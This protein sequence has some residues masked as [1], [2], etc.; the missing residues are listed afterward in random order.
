MAT[1]NKKKI[2]LGA[3]IGHTFLVLITG[4]LWLIPLL[5]IFFRKNS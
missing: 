1:R 5:I 3:V 4:G 2:G